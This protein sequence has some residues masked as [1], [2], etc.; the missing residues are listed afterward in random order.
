MVARVRPSL[1]PFQCGRPEIYSRIAPIMAHL[2]ACHNLP[3]AFA[4]TRRAAPVQRSSRRRPHSPL[5]SSGLST[6]LNPVEF[7]CV[8]ADPRPEGGAI[9]VTERHRSRTCLASGYDA[10]LVLKTSWGTG[11]GR[12]GGE[13][14]DGSPSGNASAHA[15]LR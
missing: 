9:P 11:P 1:D 14:T 3:D 5:R 12:S 6:D 15:G 10:V 8:H 2:H 13:L 4:T 7:P